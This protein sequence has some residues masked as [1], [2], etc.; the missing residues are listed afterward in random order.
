MIDAMR[1]N[2]SF[3]PTPHHGVNSVLCATL[4]AVA[5]PLRGGLTQALGAMGKIPEAENPYSAPLASVRSSSEAKQAWPLAIRFLLW[6][7]LAPVL[8]TVALLL[9]S[10]SPASLT[11]YLLLFLFIPPFLILRPEFRAGG[12]GAVSTSRFLLVSA[13]AAITGLVVAALYGVLAVIAYSI[14][15]YFSYG[16]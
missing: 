15:Q 5:T 1:P 12:F 9:I 3:K 4:H 6:G 2:N 13:A 11:V 7:L 14:W 8:G 16:A 10:P